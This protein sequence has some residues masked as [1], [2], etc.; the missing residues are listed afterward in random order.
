MNVDEAFERSVRA[1][2]CGFYFDFDGVLAP[3]QLDPDTVRL[4]PGV[5][6]ALSRLEPF[7]DAIGIISAR[8]VAFLARHFSALPVVALYGMYGLESQIAGSFAVDQ[9]AESWIPVIQSVRADAEQELPLGVYVEDK[10]MS[11]SLHYRRHPE[12]QSEVECWARSKASEH[13]LDEQYGRMVVELKPPIAIDKGAILHA[14]TRNLRSA[15]YFGDDISDMKGFQALRDRQRQDPA[16]LGVCVAVRNPE[17][18]QDLETQADITLPDPASV[19]DVLN[20]GARYFA[21]ATCA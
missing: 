12:Y 11:V 5:V 15:W 2:H 4:V 20:I 21:K 9:A 18:G 10:K 3:I 6:D 17:T 8:P 16:F 7:A 13:G 14:V 1:G 19:P